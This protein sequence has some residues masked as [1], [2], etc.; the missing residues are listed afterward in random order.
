MLEQVSGLVLWEDWRT[1][2]LWVSYTGIH[3]L[4]VLGIYDLSS[5]GSDVIE[6]AAQA[7][8]SFSAPAAARMKEVAKMSSI[9]RRFAAV[10][11]ASRKAA[12]PATA[13][14]REAKARE[15]F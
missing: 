14:A 1:I 12:A 11:E 5:A 2:K 9:A 15:V 3:V 10:A 4:I 7:R 13:S 6:F 8:R